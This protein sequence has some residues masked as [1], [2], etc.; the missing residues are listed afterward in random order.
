MEHNPYA[1]SKGKYAELNPQDFHIEKIPE[2]D[3][4]FERLK[5]LISRYRNRE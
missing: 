3:N 4:L 5:I 1:P 2:E